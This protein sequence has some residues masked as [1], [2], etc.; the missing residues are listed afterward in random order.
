M[1]SRQLAG[2]VAGGVGAF[3]GTKFAS[4]GLTE[5]R[6]TLR[7]GGS[8]TEKT[9]SQDKFFFPSAGG[10]HAPAPAKAKAAA[11]SETRKS[12][13]GIKDT[14]KRLDGTPAYKRMG[15][16]HNTLKGTVVVC[17]CVCFRDLFLCSNK[18]ADVRLLGSSLFARSISIRCRGGD[19]V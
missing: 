16:W 13:G 6:E 11:G 18:E 10:S 5:G 4:V 9:S 12:L 7:G 8:F 2:W 19:G 14:M 15:A 17:V 1:A 3:L